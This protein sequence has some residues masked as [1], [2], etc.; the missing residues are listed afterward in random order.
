VWRTLADYHTG[1]SVQNR[2]CHLC[3]QALRDIL[4]NVADPAKAP[5][6]RAYMMKLLVYPVVY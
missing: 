4:K 3:S 5:L 6:M 1:Q 2:R